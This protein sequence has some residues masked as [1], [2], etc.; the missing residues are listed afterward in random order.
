MLRRS[1]ML[2]TV[3]M[4]L[5]ILSDA[6]RGNVP[7]AQLIGQFKKLAD[8]VRRAYLLPEQ[9]VGLILY[10]SMIGKL[11]NLSEPKD[12]SPF[13]PGEFVEEETAPLESSASH[14]WSHSQA[15]SALEEP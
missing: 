15:C 2:L 8:S 7:R 5:E 14:Y 4:T 9:R 3:E 11:M 10:Q 6:G 13:P 1:N 12:G